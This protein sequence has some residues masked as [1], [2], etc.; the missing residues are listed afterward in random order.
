MGSILT[1]LTSL[2]IAGFILANV[3]SI[4]TNAI[5]GA[6]T[7]TANA[8]SRQQLSTAIELYRLDHATYPNARTS[9]QLV[10][11]L[12]TGGYIESKPVDASFFAYEQKDAGNSYSLKRK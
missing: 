3:G 6:A 11:I 7:D 8:A 10:N 5:L 1:Q 9:D 4:T 2:I 12:Y